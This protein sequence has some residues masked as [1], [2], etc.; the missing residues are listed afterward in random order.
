[1]SVP[2]KSKLNDEGQEFKNVKALAL[3]GHDRAIA[4]LHDPD[5]ISRMNNWQRRKNAENAASVTRK[6]PTRK[7]I[8]D[9]GREIRTFVDLAAT[10]HPRAIALTQ[11]PEFIRRRRNWEQKQCK[12]S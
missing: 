5:F 2:A 10:G 11:D 4:L 7:N 6:T 9:E 12:Q 3:E 8:N 1:M